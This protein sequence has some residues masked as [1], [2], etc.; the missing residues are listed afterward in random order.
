MQVAFHFPTV[1]ASKKNERCLNLCFDNVIIICSAALHIYAVTYWAAAD[2]AAELLLAPGTPCKSSLSAFR[3]PVTKPPLLA[4]NF[5]ISSC[6]RRSAAWF[7]DF[8]DDHCDK[9]SPP[10]QRADATDDSR[11]FPDPKAISMRWATR[12]NNLF[13]NLTK[14]TPGI[15]VGSEIGWRIKKNIKSATAMV[16]LNECLIGPRALVFSHLTDCSTN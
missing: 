10:V 5:L 9:S 7:L 8:P 3:K 2:T 15:A 12:C 16:P 1:A 14:S 4:R 11:T 6:L 13:C